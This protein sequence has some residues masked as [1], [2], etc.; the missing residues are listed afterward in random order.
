MFS[1]TGDQVARYPGLLLVIEGPAAVMEAHALDPAALP[2][3]LTLPE[4]A[5]AA[6]LLLF[7]VSTEELFGDVALLQHDPEG[8]PLPD[9][10][11]ELEV[12]LGPEGRGTWRERERS[13][14]LAAFRTTLR[15]RCHVLEPEPPRRVGTQGGVVT[16]TRSP[17]V[18][19][20]ARILAF[21]ED[22]MSVGILEDGTLSAP[23]PVPRPPPADSTRLVWVESSGQELYHFFDDG[24]LHVQGPAETLD[25]QTP[26]RRIVAGDARLRVSGVEVGVLTTDEE[27]GLYDERDGSW[28]FISAPGALGGAGTARMN[29]SRSSARVGVLSGDGEAWRLIERDRPVRSSSAPGAGEPVYLRELDSTFRY[30]YVTSAGEVYA[31]TAS[32]FE[33]VRTVELEGRLVGAELS[34]DQGQDLYAV[35]ARGELLELRDG[36][37][38]P[39][40]PLDLRPEGAFEVF[41]EAAFVS[42]VDPDSGERLIQR[43]RISE[44]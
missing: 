35:S 32:A 21:T 41:S 11:L 33:L 18:L 27:L 4:N 22:G 6:R 5:S 7:E 38:C 19:D 10:A 2:L 8:E 13:P 36:S 28:A 24:L 42:G 39:I 43:I 40:V 37:A 16:I 14:V 1:V 17:S 26:N 44:P 31:E 34:G 25:L 15:R 12:D 3:I 30:H 20:L 23:T 9:A 29:M